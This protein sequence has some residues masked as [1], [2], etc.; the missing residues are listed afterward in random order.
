[1]SRFLG[2]PGS[3]LK[4]ELQI[5]DPTPRACDEER[6]PEGMSHAEQQFVALALKTRRS[7]NS[8]GR[9]RLRALLKTWDE[10]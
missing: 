4:F 6:E 9:K 3:G 7:T 5:S 2:L 10:A 1:M 8:D